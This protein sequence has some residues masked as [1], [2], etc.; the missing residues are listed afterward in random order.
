M[1]TTAEQPWVNQLRHDLAALRGNWFW[2]VLLGVALVVMGAVA[3]T[4][5]GVASLATAVMFGALLLVS[6]LFEFVGSFWSRRWSGFFLHLLSGVLSVVVGV[7]LLRAPADAM[8]ILTL[9]L[10]CLLMVS[11]IFKVVAALSHRFAMWGW[12]L[13]S[14]L[15]DLVLGILIWEGWPE[16]ALWV[17][18][19]FL[20]ITL[21][22]RGFNWIALGFGLRSLPRDQAT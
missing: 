14:G 20:G 16:S 22:F 6:G 2:F 21:V 5:V 9:L 1:N 18:G 12:T 15:L 4:A 13:V 10:A 8:L 7:M 19:L 11:G 3:L 17:L